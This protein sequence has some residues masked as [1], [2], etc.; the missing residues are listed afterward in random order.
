MATQKKAASAV[1]ME[2]AFSELQEARTSVANAQQALT[3]AKNTQS[4]KVE[5]IKGLFDELKE[6]AKELGLEIVANV[7]E[8]REALDQKL[9]E[10]KSEWASTAATDPNEARRQIRAVW[11]VIGTVGG[12]IVGFGLGYLYKAVFG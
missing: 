6:N 2:Q 3:E 1:S 7:S 4:E 12:L 10:A 11:A 8:A 5:Q 9:E